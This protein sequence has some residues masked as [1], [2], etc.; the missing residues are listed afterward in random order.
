M[1]AAAVIGATV[2]EA[3]KANGADVTEIKTSF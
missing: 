2:F 1:P 3:V